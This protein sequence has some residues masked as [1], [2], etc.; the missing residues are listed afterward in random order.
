MF[1][2]RFDDFVKCVPIELLESLDVLLLPPFGV[3][4]V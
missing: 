3:T 4:P 2:E 1:T